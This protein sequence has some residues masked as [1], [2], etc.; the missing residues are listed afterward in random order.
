MPVYILLLRQLRQEDDE[1]R[2][3]LGCLQGR[4]QSQNTEEI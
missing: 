3:C 2:V 4:S 1:F